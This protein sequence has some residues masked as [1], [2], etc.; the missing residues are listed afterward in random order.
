[1]S[2]GTMSLVLFNYLLIGL[3]PLV[4]FRRDGKLNVRWCLTAVPFPVGAFLLVAVHQ[5]WVSPG[6]VQGAMATTLTVFATLLSATSIL[7][8]G[9][10]RG[11]HPQPVSLWHQENDQP[12]RLVTWGA[13][14]RIRH[15]F[16]TAFLLT[17][18][19][20]ALLA[21]HPVSLIALAYAGG[22]LTLTARREEKRLLKSPLGPSYAR[23]MTYA[24][25]FL[26]RMRSIVLQ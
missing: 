26:P 22:A 20:T 1:M 19:A 14:R 21:P 16:Y 23:Y 17:L 24:G 18:L 3:L 5:G 12:E 11:S 15:P 4:F 13:Y 7:L 8:I 6:T 2:W 10:A 25:R 9:L